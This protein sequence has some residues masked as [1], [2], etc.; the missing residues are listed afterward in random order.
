MRV[1]IAREAVARELRVPQT[2]REFLRFRRR[3][4][5]SYLNEIL[6]FQHPAEAP[7]AWRLAR[8]IRLWQFVGVPWLGGAAIVMAALLLATASWPLVPVVAL[9]FIV[10]CL[11]YA[12]PRRGRPVGGPRWP[13]LALA[14]CRYPLLFLMSLLTLAKRPSEL[15]AVGGTR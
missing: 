12:D 6:H 9:A 11:S 7:A 15:G 13:M 10:P 14:V 2:I 3:R 8:F 4:G 5:A 1:R